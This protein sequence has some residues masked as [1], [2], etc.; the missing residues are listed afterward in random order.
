MYE[1]HF[2]EEGV[3][4]FELDGAKFGYK[5]TTAGEENEWLKEYM[6][7]DDKGSYIQDVAMLNKCKIRNLKK[8]PY[9][10]ELIHKIIGLE[11]DWELLKHDEKC[12]LISKLKPKM[13]SKIIRAINKID[14]GTLQ[15]QNQKK[16]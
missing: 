12:M 6:L 11:K 13:F 8:A 14:T 7:V 9:T 16:N 10:K 1:E 3:I 15:E 2:Q 4:E 5:P